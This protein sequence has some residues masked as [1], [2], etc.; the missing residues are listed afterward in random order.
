MN[1]GEYTVEENLAA[2][3]EALPELLKDANNRG[4]FAVGRAGEQFSCW[5]TYRDALKQGY[6]K[7]GLS[8]FVVQEVLEKPRIHFITRGLEITQ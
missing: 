4:K 8:S 6:E 5:D 1:Q 7:Y 3:R 2:F